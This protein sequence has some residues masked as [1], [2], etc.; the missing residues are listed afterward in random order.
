MSCCATLCV[1]LGT[2]AA[3]AQKF[4]GLAPTPPLGWNSWNHFGCNVSEETLKSAADQMVSSGMK[5]A[6]YQYVVVDD[7][8]QGSRDQDGN[9]RADPKRFPNGMKAVADYVHAKGLKFGIYSDAG[10]KTCG[11]RP[12]SRGY[13][14]QDALTY[15]RW[16]VDYLKYDW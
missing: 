16:G 9:V 13:E 8:W 10:W 7:C 14:F 6:G 4:T 1:A 2:G 5:A 12:A 3:N 15:A 11:G